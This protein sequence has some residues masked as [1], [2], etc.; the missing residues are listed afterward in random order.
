[1][2]TCII[3]EM[4]SGRRGGREMGGVGGGEWR[5]GEWGGEGRGKGAGRQ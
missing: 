5:K 1:M 4:R 2:N 3:I